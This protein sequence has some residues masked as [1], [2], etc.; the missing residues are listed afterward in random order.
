MHRATKAEGGWGA[1]CTEYAPVS[2]DS[3]ESPYISAQLLDE[4]DLAGLALVADAA[5][6][7]GALAGIELTHT[8]AHAERRG[9]RWPAI[10]PSQLASDYQPFNVPK[11]MELDD[12]HRV[13]ADWVQAAKRACSV[14]FDIVYVYGGHSYLLTQ[15]LSPF[16][17]KRTDGYGGSLEKRARMWIETLELVK[18][19][20][21]DTASVAVRI[22]VD[23][24]FR[25]SGSGCSSPAAASPDPQSDRTDLSAWTR[26]QRVVHELVGKL[27]VR[28]AH[29]RVAHLTNDPGEPRG[30]DTEL[31]K[32]R[33]LDLVL[34]AHLL[35][36]QL[37]VR[38]D[39][40]LGDPELGSS[41]QA[42][43]ERRVLGHI[44]R[45]DAD[46]VATGVEHRAV[47]LLEHERGRGRA[48]V[49]AGTAVGEESDPHRR[50][51]KARR[52]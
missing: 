48:R 21:G 15:F 51:T 17:N 16:T 33:V 28:A 34:A 44:V 5:H 18:E 38:D 30:L 52:R 12:I 32:R 26:V 25:T 3:D 6:T 7:H 20:V 35:H 8:G 42:V 23:C 45:L 10:A 37:R 29:G 50:I 4:G 40:D 49:S 22:G 31:A 11:A 36:H 19:A 43:Q 24:R 2:L 41:A 46:R 27:V 39:F 14:G 47:V 1:V 9:T 13:Q